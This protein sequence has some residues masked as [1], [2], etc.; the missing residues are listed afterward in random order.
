MYRINTTFGVFIH[1][2]YWYYFMIIYQNYFKLLTSIFNNTISIM[3]K[4]NQILAISFLGAAIFFSSTSLAQQTDKDLKGEIKDKAT[5]EA[6]KEAKQFEKDGYAVQPGALPMDKQI[7]SSWMKQYQEDENGYPSYY[8]ASGNAVAGTQSAAK[9]QALDVARTELAGQISAS[10]GAIIETNIANQQLTA[11]EAVTV[12]QTVS[13]SSTIIAQQ[14]GRV[15]TLFEVF[16]KVN[17]DNIEVNIRIGYSQKMANDMAKQAIKKELEEK[18]N[19]TREK[20]DKLMN[21]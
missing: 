21:F 14:L 7:E 19:V 1:L 9:I 4:L 12:Q 2:N 11:E 18:T 3:K 10:I 8:V 5:K 15:I 20:L 6:R 17:K 13:A 16:R